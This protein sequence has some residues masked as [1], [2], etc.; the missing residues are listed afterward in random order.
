MGPGSL[1]MT[2]SEIIVIIIIFSCAPFPWGFTTQ[3]PT[4]TFCVLRVLRFEGEEC[5]G[6]Y[7]LRSPPDKEDEFYR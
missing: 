5:F 2:N 4:P 1:L 7:S 3:F 6:I